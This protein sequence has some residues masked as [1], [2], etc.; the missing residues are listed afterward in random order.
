MGQAQPRRACG[1]QPRS[2][3]PAQSLTKTFAD[4]PSGERLRKAV[5]TRA[6]DGLSERS[7]QLLHLVPTPVLRHQTMITTSPS[8][9]P[10][11]VS[12]E[13]WKNRSIPEAP[14]RV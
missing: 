5:E 4:G 14:V 2:D 10:V 6:I 13:L 9:R 8:C 3:Q 1:N 12:S 7:Q 11:I